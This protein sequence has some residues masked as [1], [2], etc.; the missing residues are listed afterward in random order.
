[1]LSNVK[2]ASGCF[3]RNRGEYEQFAPAT[4]PERLKDGTKRFYPLESLPQSWCQWKCVLEH[5]K[6]HQKQFSGHPEKCG[7]LLTDSARSAQIK[8]N[9]KE[10]YKVECDCLTKLFNEATGGTGKCPKSEIQCLP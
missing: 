1:M 10:G 3:R 9:E 4:P 2:A 7:E 6:S 5:E 8:A